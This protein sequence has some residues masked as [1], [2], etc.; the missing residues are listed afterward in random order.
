[1]GDVNSYHILMKETRDE[2]IK[3]WEEQG[4]LDPDC[5]GCKERYESDKMPMDVFAPN[6]AKQDYCRS[7]KGGRNHCTCDTCF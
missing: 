4:W 6:H 3:R 2:Q 7:Y 5:N 1:M